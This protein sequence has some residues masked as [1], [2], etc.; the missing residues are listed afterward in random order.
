[1]TRQTPG[2][3]T[4]DVI[5]RLILL[6]DEAPGIPSVEEGRYQVLASLFKVR[7]SKIEQWFQGDF[8]KANKLVEIAD[9]FGCSLDW[10]IFGYEC[11]ERKRNTEILKKMIA[12][13]D[14]STF[15]H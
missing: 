15:M 1:M 3:K 13:E 7:E 12:G 10:L 2:T 4:E 11:Q 8:P 6:C 14:P 9:Y 5:K